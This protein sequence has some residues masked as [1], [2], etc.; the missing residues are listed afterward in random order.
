MRT[1]TFGWRDVYEVCSSFHRRWTKLKP[2]S[3]LFQEYHKPISKLSWPSH[4]IQEAT[5]L[6][7]LKI[8]YFSI[9]Y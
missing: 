5:P 2:F 9:K 7:F 8:L 4:E 1:T 3:L 6:K